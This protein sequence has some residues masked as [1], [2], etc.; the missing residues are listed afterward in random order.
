MNLTAKYYGKIVDQL[1]EKYHLEFEGATSGHCMKVTGFGK[2]YLPL[3]LERISQAYSHIQVYQLSEEQE[4][5]S[6]VTSTKLIELRNKQEKPLLILVPANSRT[7]AEDSYGNATF[8]DITPDG[9]ESNVFLALEGEIPDTANTIWRE[10]IFF[11]NSSKVDTGGKTLLLLAWQELGFEV[12]KLGSFLH[13][14][15]LV[16]DDDIHKDF[17][18]IRS[19]LNFNLQSVRELTAF[20]KSIFERVRR[21]P[22]DKD[23]VQEEVVNLLRNNQGIRSASSLVKKI[24]LEYDDLN[25]KNW[26]IP[27]LTEKDIRL[28]VDDIKSADK[29]SPL[30]WEDGIRVLE[31]T[32]SRRAK[33]KIR[34]RTLPKPN[35]IIELT[36]FRVILMAVDG[37][38]GEYIQ[39]LR[40]PKNTNTPRVY[41]DLT[42][43]LDPNLIEEGSYFLKV[44]AEDESGNTLNTD[45]PFKDSDVQLYWEEISEEE[46]TEKASIKR[47]LSCDSEDFYFS[48]K[49]D[50]EEKDPPEHRKKDKLENAI[51]A[52]FKYRIEL[53]RAGQELAI[54]EPQP[55]ASVW[56]EANKEKLN[57]TFHIMYPGNHNYQINIPGKLVR[58]EQTLLKNP[59]KMGGVYATLS[60][61]STQLGFSSIKFR[62]SIL[63]QIVPETLMSSRKALFKSIQ[64][65]APEKTGIFETTEFDSFKVLAE[66][67]LEELTNWTKELYRKFQAITPENSDQKVEL[68]NLFREL[69]NIDLIHLRTTMPNQHEIKVKLLSPIHPLRLHWVNSLCNLF[70]GWEQKTIEIESYKKQWYNKMDQ[71]FLGGLSM[72]TN[73][74]VLIDSDNST[75]FQYAGEIMHG[76]GLYLGSSID[77]KQTDTLNSTS[78][79]IKTYLSELLNI[80]PSYRID[81]DLNERLIVKHIKNYL[82]QHPYVSTLVINLFNAGDAIT[83]SNALVTIEGDKLWKGVNYEIR[84]FKGTDN[85]IEHGLGVKELLNPEYSITEE[86]EAFSQPSPNRLFPKLRF[87]INPIKDYLDEPEKFSSHVSFLVSPFPSKTTLYKSKLN[88]RSFYLNGL[89]SQPV[90]QVE[91]GEAHLEWHKYL[92]SFGQPNIELFEYLQKFTAGALAGKET[93]SLP[94]TSL[95]LKEKDK[96]LL[97]TV[98]VYSD[99]VVTFDK[100]M[101]PEVYDLPGEDGQIPFLL[102]YVPGEE[103]SGISSYLTTR[104]TSEIVNLLKPHFEAFNITIDQENNRAT[105]EMLLEDL[106]TV[107]S[108]IIMQLNSGRNKAFEVIG[109]ALT[110]RVLEKKGVLENAFIIPIDLHQNLFQ[111]VDQESKS[112]ADNLIVRIKP[113]RRIIEIAVVE[114]KCRKQLGESEKADLRAK[115]KSQITNTIEILRS[116]FDPEYNLSY[117]RLDRAIKNKELKSLLEF[118]VS[119]AKRY[120]LL[121][122]NTYLH[123]MD[124]LQD[125]DQGFTFEFKELG[126]VYDFNTDIRHSK[127]EFDGATYFWLGSRLIGE[128]LDPDSDLN[129][130]RLEHTSEDNEL[131]TFFGET[132]PLSPFLEQVLTRENESVDSIVEE[133]ILPEEE[134]VTVTNI[135]IETEAEG[136]SKDGLGSN[137]VEDQLMP[138]EKPYNI[139]QGDILIGETGG[140]EQYGILGRTLH[141]KSIALDA[142]KVNTISLFG[143]QGGGKSYT[144]G[145][146]TEM[147]LKPISDINVL[148]KPLAG[149][150]FHYSET[151]DYA[152]EATSMIYK[153]DEISELEALK[154]Q[155]GASPDH[156]EDVILLTPSDKLDERKAQYPS[157]EVSPINFNSKELNV[158]D[159]MFL[160]GAVGNDA[161]YIRQL[162]AIMRAQRNNLTLKG[163]RE[164]VEEAES[165]T[166]NQRNLALQRLDF[167][168]QY[169]D[170]KISLKD[171]LRPGRLIIVDLR[172]EF[173][174]RDEALGIFV[175]MLN[176][177]SGVKAVGDLS[178]NKFIVFDEA[179]KYMNN[180]DL[181]NTIVTAIRE[182]RH[183]GVSIMI[184]S[185]DPPS[186]PNE[187][188]ELSTIVLLHKFNSPQWLR[189]VQKSITP[190]NA[191]K[192]EDLSILGPGEAFLWATKASDKSIISRPTKIKTRPRVTK[193]GGA[194]IEAI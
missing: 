41:R 37:E 111:E 92:S 16:P 10:I 31:T 93:N 141:G 47:K 125:L 162:K 148:P 192:P 181:T 8:K 109:A 144:I 150:I 96:V 27:E 104:P 167:A 70:N 127:D 59:E 156:L 25:F 193:H 114:I 188:I 139:P 29:S 4:G 128:I 159:W 170:D 175:I 136:D 7:A 107:S 152:P 179:H 178:F 100:N 157:I 176:I 155:Y 184:A 63:D 80:D 120:N 126:L 166:N 73:P 147:M 61:D 56:L 153:N 145:T 142:N 138:Y 161:T 95:T 187:I 174:E 14:L 151:M 94:S 17:G 35:E 85:F 102:D 135:E 137:K 140:S 49:E 24:A 133:T 74:L 64:E 75:N 108:S 77:E 172:D 146:I 123:Y 101:G 68:Q 81:S 45:D 169:I 42:V 106:R 1:I 180:R 84:L 91:D 131:V 28:S 9:L 34:V 11:L 191:L 97:H 33:V 79:Q 163:I 121:S 115:I 143:V 20:N 32:I 39:E 53:F 15:G 103:V 160:L 190:L 23:S 116:H 177:F 112:R 40:R 118:Y 119:R 38:A 105:L 171:K 22:L 90:I 65:S 117:D 122:E 48:I 98:H 57:R 36:H 86:A 154:A 110:K 51:Q 58:L 3:L 182:M 19:R 52:Y 113:D 87:S 60:N 183:K 158:Q 46:D 129:T 76:W 55:E 134:Q 71:L 88:R 30:R 12:E 21:L 189:H 185:Q 186:L 18:R 130:Q 164:S 124:F 43:E 83:F 5:Q 194:T 78:R 66:K 50:E 6:F 132:I 26:S 173:I 69:Q 149:V 62:E 54:P 82:N 165:L 89:V 67:Y 99:W 2:E 13:H 44:L 168:E 72:D